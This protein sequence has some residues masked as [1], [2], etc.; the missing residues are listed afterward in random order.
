MALRPK[1]RRAPAVRDAPDF[2][3]LEAMRWRLLNS[4]FVSDYGQKKLAA[5]KK[6]LEFFQ[7]IPRRPTPTLMDCT[8]Q[9]VLFYYLHTSS[10]GRTTVH[11]PT[12]HRRPGCQCPPGRHHKI[13]TVGLVA[14][15]RWVRLMVLWIR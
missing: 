1:R 12:C 6:M 10:I 2:P 15:A 14:R 13:V 8:P 3:A 4:R 7:F 11:T 5:A 9:D